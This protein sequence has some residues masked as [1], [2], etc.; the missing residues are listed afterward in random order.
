[1][2]S[3]RHAFHAGNHAD[4][5]KHLVL[6]Q[7]TRYLGQKEKPFWY[8][9]THAG[10]G[11]YPLDTAQ[12]AKLA[13]YRSGVARLWDWERRGPVPVAITEYLSVVRGDNPDGALK[14]Y[15]G[16]PRVAL[17]S[18]RDDDRLRLF[19]LHG[20]DVLHLREACRSAGRRVRV[21]HA[22]GFAGLKALLPPPTRRALVLIDPAYEEKRDYE[23]VIQALKEG[24]QRFPTGIYLLW[25]PQL[26]RLE[27]HDLPARLKRLPAENWL[28]VTLR[29]RTPTS[30]GFGMHGSGLFV[31]NP[32]WTL[33]TVLRETM[34]YLLAVLGQ[35]DGAGFSLESSQT[36]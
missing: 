3:Y 7:L 13:E 33:E 26:T 36:P 15:P 21:E 19:E 23:R 8:I 22:D 32:P 34:P 11:V 27:A 14:A 35:N 4:V 1:M 16:S 31:V 30:D 6:L 29:V 5:L 24:L 20:R 2:L 17:A 10:A 28:H 18:M 9:D 12:A 25:Y